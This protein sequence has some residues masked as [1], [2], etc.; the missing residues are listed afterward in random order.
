MTTADFYR[1]R[2]LL[3]IANEYLTAATEA[4]TDQHRAFNAAEAAAY[5]LEAYQLAA[6][7]ALPVTDAQRAEPE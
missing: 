3:D 2:N 1:F 5:A 7:Y 4:T 6:P